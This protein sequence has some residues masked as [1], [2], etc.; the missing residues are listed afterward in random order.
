MKA[1]FPYFGGKSR[2]ADIV[3]ER[4]GDCANRKRERIWFSPA[5]KP[6]VIGDLFATLF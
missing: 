3:W 6:S 4:F 1:P 2:A 5:C